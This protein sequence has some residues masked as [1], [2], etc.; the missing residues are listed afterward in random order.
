MDLL[1]SVSV[2]AFGT[3]SFVL[4]VNNIIQEDK[5]IFGNWL[6]L[7][8]G[9]FSFIWDLGMG[10][11]TMQSMAEPA[12]FWRSFYLIGVL[13]LVSISGVLAGS[14]MKTPVRLKRVVDSYLIFGAMLVYPFISVKENCV[15]VVTEYGMTYQATEH[16]GRGIYT[17]FICGVLVLMCVEIVYCLI[18]HAKSREAVMA[19]AVFGVMLL[20]GSGLMLDTFL[21]D[22][23]RPAFPITAITQPVAVIFAYAMSRR[24]RI[25]NISIQNLS[26]Y[27]Y[28]SVNVPMLIVDAERYPKICNA[29]AIEFF[30][31][32]DELLKQKKMEELFDTKTMVV[33]NRE[34]EA[35]TVE[36]TCLLNNR[37]CR[38]QI[39]HIKDSFNNFLSDIIVV[40]DM[41]ETYKSIEELNQAKEEAVKANEAKS[42]FLANMSH[43]IRTPMNSI[44]GMSEILLR[45]NLDEQTAENVMHIYSAGKSL[46]EIIND[47]LD[48]SKIES[49]KYELVESEYKLGNVVL[50]VINLIDARLSQKKQ[51]CLEYEI[52]S[53]VPGVLYGDA[54]RIRQILINILG[55]AVK[56][57]QKG[58]IKLTVENKPLEGEFQQLIFKVQDTGIGIKEEDI[59]KLFGIFNQVDT[60]RNRAVQGT[61]LGLAISKELCE[62]MDGSI[63]VDSIYG[64]GTT[65]T[66]TIKQQVIDAAP[67]NLEESCNHHVDTRKSSFQPSEMKW[68]SEMRVLVVDDNLMNIRVVEEMLSTYNIK[69][70]KADSGEEALEKIVEKKYDFVFMD[71]MMPEMDG[72]ETLH[73]IRQKNGEYYQTV[74]IIALTANTVAGTREQLLREGFNDFLEKPMERSVLERVLRRNLPIEKIFE[75]VIDTEEEKAKK[76]LLPKKEVVE[77]VE[78]WEQFLIQKGLDVKKAIR[79]CN[80]QE[81]YLKILRGYCKEVETILKQ[82]EAQ[83]KENDW[84]NY[85][86][87]VHGLKSSMYSVGATAVADMAKKLELAGKNSDVTY[88]MTYHTELIME[89]RKL[90]AE[91]KQCKAVYREEENKSRVVE[92]KVKEKLSKE[93]LKKENLQEISEEELLLILESVESAMYN[94][95]EDKMKTLLGKLKNCS[96]QGRVMEDVISNALHKIEMSDY[97][98]AVEMLIRWKEQIIDEEQRKC[99]KS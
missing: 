30:D 21:V 49:G 11:F 74:P 93:P 54:I 82:L 43:E 59:K 46:L 84:K 99:G 52:G 98:T 53:Q 2:I 3:V 87:V 5:N 34:E 18:K 26:G 63:E 44:I 29:T 15:F 78:D 91:I 61:G 24:T 4:A 32:P 60:K 48:I 56:F 31:M 35:E 23:S 96:Y 47:I 90:F 33:V 70:T 17:F 69:V 71:Y 73:R 28:A 62:L 67:M 92:V 58:F 7:F 25:N 39:S 45:S 16:I 64:V 81:A 85:T 97:M 50:D 94:L 57:T 36:C 65:F 10:V 72:V 42:A 12:A 86:I 66:I 77:T 41:T 20:I 79:Y 27:I 6:F 13:G 68:N 19:K 37:I 88:I 22:S 14:W 89:C 40:N 9:L 76:A 80:G 8:M 95:D 75:Q 1:I 83:Y 38:L 55:N 51:V